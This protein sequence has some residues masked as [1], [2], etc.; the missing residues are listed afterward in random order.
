MLVHS[1]MIDAARTSAYLLACS[2][3]WPT[4]TPWVSPSPSPSFSE[5]ASASV[6]S[7]ILEPTGIKATCPAEAGAVTWVT[8]V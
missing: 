1:M 6:K 2:R 5:S 3:S 4:A 7:G 8:W